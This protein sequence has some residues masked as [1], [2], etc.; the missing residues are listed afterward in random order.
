MTTETI[1]RILRSLPLKTP[2]RASWT[3]A[4][5]DDIP[6]FLSDHASCER[7]AHAAALM[8]VNKFPEYPD[9]QDQ[10]LSLAR[11]E[12]D[13]FHQVFRL[14]RERNLSLPPD[15]TDLYV[16]RLLLHGRHPR[17]EHLLD[18]LLAVALIE[19]RSCERF[20]L[21]ALALDPGPLRD[22]YTNF[23]IEE[24]RHFPLF[25]RVTKS[26]FPADEVDQRLAEF[27]ELEAGICA[28][29]PVRASVH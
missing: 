3:K 1:Q 29:L 28:E 22:F 26:I 7:K 21:L 14:L 17:R 24:S 20:C 8:L 6:G 13:H 18:R 2:T 4:V 5:L 19:A 27:L 25:I 9:L 15:E 23:A 16:K 10:M 11:E 12:L